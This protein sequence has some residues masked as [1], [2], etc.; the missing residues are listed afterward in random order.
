MF[1]NFISLV[2][3]LGAAR[4]AFVHPGLLQTAT[5]F[6][7]I[8]S[9]VAAKEEPW[10]TGYNKLAASEYA[11]SSYVPQA[12]SVVYRGSDG[13]HAENYPLLYEDV[14]AAYVLSIMYEV[15]GDTAYADAA[16]TIMD[17]WSSTLTDLGGNSDLYLA[18][19]IY[20]YEFAQSGEILRDYSG[21]DNF[22]R[23]QTMMVD[24]FYV[25]VN[26]WFVNH[27]A[28]TYASNALSVYAGWDLCMM[29]A[30]VAIG[31][32]TDNQT[33]YDQ[34]RNWFINGTGNGKQ[35]NAIPY[36][37]TYDNE[38]IA[39]TQE[40]GRDQGHNMLDIALLA[41]LGLMAYNQGD[42]ILAYNDSIILSAWV[43]TFLTTRAY[44]HEDRVFV[45]FLC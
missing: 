18:A 13:V 16:V 45:T 12:V 10:L 2:S 24:V 33:M 40:S 11:N 14:A 41:S 32:L 9:K 36:L 39:Q 3:F 28:G 37:H 20:G 4:A 27:D 23:F 17:A 1:S 43:L 22:E 34:G 7:R 19:G 31:I 38:L 29:T 15:T 42:D 8:T 25:K 26:D 21:W 6:E 5:D 35:T 30:A 44:L